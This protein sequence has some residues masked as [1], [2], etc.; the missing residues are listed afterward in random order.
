METRDACD[1][2]IASAFQHF[3]GLAKLLADE[4]S[5]ETDFVSWRR[6]IVD[7]HEI[8]TIQCAKS[9]SH[10]ILPS[11][12]LNRGITVLHDTFFSVVTHILDIYIF[13]C[14]A[15]FGTHVCV[16]RIDIN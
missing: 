8:C 4:N 2:R 10:A 12:V 6:E 9:S 13:H 5:I 7:S 14:N 11:V 1:E 3:V 15:M 16:L